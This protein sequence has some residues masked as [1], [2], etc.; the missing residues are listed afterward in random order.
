MAGGLIRS[1]LDHA[2]SMAGASAV[3]A[4]SIAFAIAIP[5]GHASCTSWQRWPN[6]PELC[7]DG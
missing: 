3:P 4:Y 1:R 7:D 6:S 2:Q 5:L